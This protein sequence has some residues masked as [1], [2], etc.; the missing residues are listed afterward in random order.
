MMKKMS[1]TVFLAVLSISVVAVSFAQDSD[2]EKAPL[3][4]REMMGKQGMMEHKGM[5]DHGGRKCG[6]GEMPEMMGM[7]RTSMA[8]TSDGGVVIQSGTKLYKYDKNL[9]L[10]KETQIK[11]DT[12][13]M[14]K[15][16]TPMM[17]KCCEMDEK[18]EGAAVAPGG[19]KENPA[20]PGT[21]QCA[22][23][24]K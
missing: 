1:L 10:V 13:G 6:R 19:A 11:I 3:M 17:E 7:S 21:P 24:H 18:V 22:S 2:K 14:Q 12:E 23:G 16:M 4:G 9:N 5:K 20:G 15:M 8:A